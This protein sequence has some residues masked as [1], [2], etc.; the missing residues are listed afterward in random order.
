MK[1]LKLNIYLCGPMVNPYGRVM[2][3]NQIL[4]I[5]NMVFNINIYIMEKLYNE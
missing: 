3:N 4:Q 5:K 1:N 2:I